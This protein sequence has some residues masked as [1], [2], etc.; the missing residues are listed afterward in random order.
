MSVGDSVGLLLRSG[1]GSVVALYGVLGRGATAVPLNPAL[2]ADEVARCLEPCRPRLVVC[3]PDVAGVLAGRL[4]GVVAVDALAVSTRRGPHADPPVDPDRTAFYLFST[5]S[6]GRP[7]RVSRSH[8]MMV[9]EADQYQA[10]VGLGPQDVIAGVAPVFHS[11]GLCCVMLSAVRSGAR[12]VL[13]RE[14]Q[15][16]TV[17]ASVTRE[18]ATVF[19]GSPFH[20]SLM[21]MLSRR[22]GVDL[23][24]LRWCVSCGASAPAA[25]VSRFRAVFGLSVRQLYGASEVGSVAFNRS[26]DPIATAASVGT[27]LPGV[28]VRIVSPDGG[29]LAA[30]ET[31]E[32]AVSSAA[33]STRYEDLPEVSAQAFRDGW[34]FSG[35]L[36]HLDAEGAL[37]VTGRTKLLINV[38]GNK[39][40]PLEVEGV[41]EQ[42]P[43]VLEAAVVGLPGAHGLE[44]VKAAVVPRSATRLDAEELRA[45]C[46]ERLIG[47]K[48]P[49]VVEVRASLPR[50]PTGKLLRKDLL[51]D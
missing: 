28:R 7:K 38:A 12:A 40:D 31:G 41:L 32:I 2:R 6:T 50:S 37:H 44:V 46:A 33:G 26:Q 36:G 29:D 24:S 20:Y 34:F 4:S 30:G 14:F 16:E 51:D 5:G 17:M 15:P 1:L 21:S 35:D 10:A 13:Y 18:R 3:E 11:Y 48:V 9:A 19:T 47:Y 8:R 42:H 49:R 39:V 22:P 25:V 43:G 23:S 27:P 45:F